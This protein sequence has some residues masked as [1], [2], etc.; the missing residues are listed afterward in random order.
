M[1]QQSSNEEVLTE[2][3]F[4]RLLRIAKANGYEQ[5]YYIIKTLG[6]TGCR[7]DELKFFDSKYTLKK[8]FHHMIIIL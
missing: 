5:L 2:T 8:I 1:Q 7:I 3:D 6:M 4:K